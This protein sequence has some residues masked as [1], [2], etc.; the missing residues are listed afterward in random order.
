[1]GRRIGR[2]EQLSRPCAARRSLQGVLEIFLGLSLVPEK[3]LSRVRLRSD[4]VDYYDH[5]FGGS[6]A[7]LVLERLSRGGPDRATALRMLESAG[8]RV[9]MYGKVRDLARALVAGGGKDAQVVVHM[10]PMGHRGEGK[11]LLLV[12][13]AA[14]Q[15]P[16]CLGTV[17]IRP[18]G[19]FAVSRRLLFLGDRH[20]WLGY[21]SE[22]GD[23]RS[24]WGDVVV[25]VLGCSPVPPM[26]RPGRSVL[27]IDFVPDEYGELWA[28]DLNVAPRVRGTGVEEVLPAREAA[29]A[30]A[31][32]FCRYECDSPALF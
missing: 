11:V 1:M 24:N 12:V 3:L 28:V 19:Q 25:R 7:E 26:R 29:G 18:P 6:W 31:A 14:I 2:H 13:E 10:D 21:R 15:H 22:S 5:W 17:Y 16:D 30:I 9:P 32:W 8:L 4:F 20:F 23:W 27:A